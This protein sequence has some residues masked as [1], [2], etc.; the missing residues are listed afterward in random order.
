MHITCF[1]RRAVLTVHPA[2]MHHEESGCNETVLA[3]SFIGP[4]SLTLQAKSASASQHHVQS[5]FATSLESTRTALKPLE[6]R[7]GPKGCSVRFSKSC[8]ELVQLLRAQMTP[9]HQKPCVQSSAHYT[10]AHRQ[11]TSDL[12]GRSSGTDSTNLSKMVIT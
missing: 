4:F 3:G 8:S 12:L 11:R 6:H 2:F 9:Q 10:F 1:H 7:I 5:A